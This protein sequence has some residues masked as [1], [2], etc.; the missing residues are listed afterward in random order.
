MLP[1]DVQN[2]TMLAPNLFGKEKEAYWKSFDWKLALET[3]MEGH[4]LDFSGEYEFI[5]TAYHFPTTHMVAPEE[6]ALQCRACHADQGR[7]ATLSGFYLPGR[8]NNTILDVIGWLAV[9]GSLAGVAVHGIMRKVL[10]K[11]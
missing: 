3:G 7:L 9:F 11:K 2:K 10:A 4:G 5:E 1:Y 6:E 8:D